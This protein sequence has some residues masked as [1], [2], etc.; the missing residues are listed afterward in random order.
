MMRKTLKK[1]LTLVLCAGM[2]FSA[3]ACI[4]ESTEL[5]PEIPVAV[6]DY[7]S[8]GK[9]FDFYSYISPTN[10][11]YTVDGESYFGGED[12]QTV[13]SYK[14]M[15]DCGF[16]ILYVNNNSAYYT[17]DWDTSEAKK[18]FELG[19]QAGFR[20]ILIED[21]RL[22][23]LAGG[24]PLYGDAKSPFNSQEELDD[25][26]AEYL[27]TYV[28]MPGF[29]GVQIQDEPTAAVAKAYGQLYKSLKRVGKERFGI[30][31][32]YV[33]INFLP[34]G[35]G[36][37]TMYASEYENYRDAYSKYYDI[38]LQET[39]A[40]LI[41]ADTY[42]FR[43]GNFYPGFYSGIQVMRERAT[44][45]DADISYV[46][47]SFQ[48]YT[49]TTEVFRMVDKSCMYLEMNSLIGFGSKEFGY[50]TYMPHTSIDSAN[51]GDAGVGSFLT[52]SGER[53]NIWYGAQSL[54]ADAQKFAP[55]VLN[56]DFKG[57]K[58]YTRTPATYKISNYF[59]SWSEN[60]YNTTCDWD[61][62]Y[63]FAKIKSVEQDNDISLLTEMYDEENS[64]YMYMVQN[65][66]DPINSR[67][68]R[69][70]MNVSV[71]FSDEYDWVAEYDCGELR[72]VKLNNGKYEKT[73]SAGYA[74][75]LI[76]L[77]STK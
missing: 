35:V 7:Y 71:E 52:R 2:L 11:T 3:T 57:A 36:D 25:K 68:G 75:Y 27:S 64:L 46:L 19:Y 74:V 53:T 29:Y 49:G 66:I 77:S 18:C 23:Y 54:F 44:L 50:Y 26:V 33:H 15:L 20:K 59:T 38:F 43:G 22:I 60:K 12:L 13:E 14:E 45:A 63:E 21:R 56:Y 48:A 47:Q 69:T 5:E 73:L 34:V 32:L 72:Y 51:G 67:I 24:T 55:V 17:G 70:E 41:S 9:Q 4:D 42:A 6:P 62:S 39:G 37:L 31:D 28:N 30:D 16:T 1:A 8:S 61:N 76:P 65:I 40:K 10:G 58:M